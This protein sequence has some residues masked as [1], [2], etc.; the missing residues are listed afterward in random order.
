MDDG[1]L[2]TLEG[3]LEHYAAGGRQILSGPYTGR[4]HDNPNKDPL[5]VGSVSLSKTGTT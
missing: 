4:G 3:V 2:A 1:S 5:I